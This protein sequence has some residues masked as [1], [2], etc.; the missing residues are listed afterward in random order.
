MTYILTQEPKHKNNTFF[1]QGTNILIPG[2]LKF[3]ALSKLLLE[4]NQ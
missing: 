3:K 2:Q 4:L 1:D